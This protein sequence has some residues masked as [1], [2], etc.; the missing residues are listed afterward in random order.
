MVLLP[1]M[2]FA[3]DGE[4]CFGKYFDSNYKADPDGG[5]ALYINSV[6]VGHVMGRFRPYIRLETLIDE[7]RFIGRVRPSSIKYYIGITA[8][9]IKH[10]NLELSHVC[11]HPI[12]SFGT[13]EQYNLIK[14]RIK[15]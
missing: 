5:I 10:I 12:D 6:E 3:F 7:Y 1:T 9:I 11:W 14:M 15:F 4:L 2:S 8:S 13:V